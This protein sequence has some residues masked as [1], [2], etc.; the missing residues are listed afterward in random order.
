MTNHQENK[1]SMYIT[2]QQVVNFHYEVWKDSK[3]FTNQVTTFESIIAEIM[4]V[5][6]VQESEITGVTK[7]KA[8]ACFTAVEKGITAAMKISAYASV[9]G[10]NKLRDRVFYSYSKLIRSRDTFVL[11]RLNIIYNAAVEHLPEMADYDLT[12]EHVDELAVLIS[13]YRKAVEDPRQ[14]ITN[15]SRATQ[16]LAEL[17]AQADR[18]LK[19]RM[20]TLLEHFKSL[21]SEFYK[22]Y[23]NARKIVD[24]G[25]RKRVP[26]EKAA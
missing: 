13:N 15:R 19:E 6:T 17:F 14:A 23:K 3:A 24:L 25:H 12:Q 1:L 22:Q 18:I 2:T 7:D 10:N 26:L 8:E 9:I 5:R 4:R 16:E 11:D 21:S 20:D